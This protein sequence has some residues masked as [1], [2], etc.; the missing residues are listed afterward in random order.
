MLTIN[1]IMEY[2]ED[3]NFIYLVIESCHGEYY[4]FNLNIKEECLYV[5]NIVS[6]NETNDSMVLG[7][8]VAR[9]LLGWIGNTDSWID[10]ISGMDD[11]AGIANNKVIA[12]KDNDFGDKEDVNDE[13]EEEK[14]LEVDEDEEELEETEQFEEETPVVKKTSAL[15]KSE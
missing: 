14:E 10:F 2:E 4:G 12:D 11:G 5:R 7:W 3:E 1:D 8:K 13:E 15:K 9:T 6:C